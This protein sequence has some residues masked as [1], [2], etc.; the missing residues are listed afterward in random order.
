M[1]MQLTLRSQMTLLQFSSPHC[2]PHSLK[3]VNKTSRRIALGIS[4]DDRMHEEAGRAGHAQ[5]PSCPTA[6]G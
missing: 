5:Q 2:L 1:T 3:I 4:V 6:G